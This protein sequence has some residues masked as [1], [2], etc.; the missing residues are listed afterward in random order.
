VLNISNKQIAECLEL[1]ADL[2]YDIVGPMKACVIFQFKTLTI[3]C[4]PRRTEILRLAAKYAKPQREGSGK[5]TLPRKP[6]MRVKPLP[7]EY[8][9]EDGFLT[10]ED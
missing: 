7:P 8:L 6:T 10:F 1:I 2:H 4:A 5:N 3:K 9:Q